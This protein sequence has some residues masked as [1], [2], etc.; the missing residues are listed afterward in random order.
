MKN[1]VVYDKDGNKV[2]VELL[3][4]TLETISDAMKRLD[5]SRVTEKLLV[6]LIK[7]DTGISATNIRMVLSSY[8]SLDQRYLKPSKM[9]QPS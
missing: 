7:D 6:A 5:K 8:R 9:K 2:G 3:Q 1:T 4:E